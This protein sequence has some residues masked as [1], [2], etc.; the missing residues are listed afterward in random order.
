MKKGREETIQTSFTAFLELFLTLLLF[1]I[2]LVSLKSTKIDLFV[3]K[4][5]NDFPHVFSSL[6][7]CSLFNLTL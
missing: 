7:H 4:P 2:F 3:N 5:M 1:N 6:L